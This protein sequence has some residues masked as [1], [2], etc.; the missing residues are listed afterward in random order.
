MSLCLQSLH[1][2]QSLL[3]R[4][5]ETALC[6]NVLPNTSP[7]ILSVL[8]RFIIFFSH[9]HVGFILLVYFS[10]CLMLIFV[11]FPFFFCPTATH[12]LRLSLSLKSFCHMMLFKLFE[13]HF[14][15]H[16]LIHSFIYTFNM[17]C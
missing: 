12:S 6:Q 7:H 16:S 10:F 8:I 13:P 17:Y 1:Y 9:K 5:Q 3:P 2:F 11:M 15:L 14:F 4:L